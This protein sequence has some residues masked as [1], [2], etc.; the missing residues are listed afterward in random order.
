[1]PRD[2]QRLTMR[3][4]LRARIRRGQRRF[5]EARADIDAALNWLLANLPHD[6]QTIGIFSKTKSSID[7]AEQGK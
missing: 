2:E 5:A 3:Y 4:A 7:A 6:E 1:M